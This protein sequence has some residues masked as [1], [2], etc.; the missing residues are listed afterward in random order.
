MATDCDSQQLIITTNNK[1]F[2]CSA[3]ANWNQDAKQSGD[4][5]VDPGPQVLACLYRAGYDEEKPL[6]PQ[7]AENVRRVL[8]TRAIRVNLMPGV[9]ETC[10]EA[11]SEYCSTNVKPTEEMNCLQE[12]FEKKIFKERYPKCHEEVSKFTTVRLGILFWM[13]T[14]NLLISNNH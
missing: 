5:K 14:P 9:E 3:I 8:R 6:S 11:L 4:M 10:R 2:R 1:K 13:P 7:C 12:Q